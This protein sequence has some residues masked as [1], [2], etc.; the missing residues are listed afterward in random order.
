MQVKQHWIGDN[1]KQEGVA[2]NDI[3]KTNLPDIRVSYRHETLLDELQG[4]F[5][6]VDLKHQTDTTSIKTK[7][8]SS[9]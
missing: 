5:R 2:G 9:K 6:A 4:I 8:L 7:A 1:Y 3:Q